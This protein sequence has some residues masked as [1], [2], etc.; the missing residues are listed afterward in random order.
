MKFE[1]EE[2]GQELVI[3]RGKGVKNSTKR[4]GKI[5]HV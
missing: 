3:Y 2:I 4:F 1:S 5:R